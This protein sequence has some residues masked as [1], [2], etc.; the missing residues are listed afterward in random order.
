LFKVGTKWEEADASTVEWMSKTEFNV[1]TPSFRK[2]GPRTV[3]VYIKEGEDLVSVTK[4]TFSFY[5]DTQCDKS[6][7][8]GPGIHHT[9]NAGED[10]IFIIN[11]RDEDGNNRTSGR[12]LD[13]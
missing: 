7:A 12:W 3:D 10:T 8:Y 1:H 5:V 9:Q 13:S 11:A 6:C 4:T 2:Y